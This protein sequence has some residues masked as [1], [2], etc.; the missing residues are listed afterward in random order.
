[1]DHDG[2]CS[3]IGWISQVASIKWNQVAA[4]ASTVT[5]WLSIGAGVAGLAAAKVPGPG[6]AA[7]VALEGFAFTLGAVSTLLDCSVSTTTTPCRAGL[8]LIGFGALGTA[9]RWSIDAGFLELDTVFQLDVF[10]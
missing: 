2:D 9:G 7:A 8:F 6:W 4:T 10:D 5:V 3:D 1:M